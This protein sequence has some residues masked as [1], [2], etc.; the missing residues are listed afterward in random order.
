M[1]HVYEKNG[2]WYGD[3]GEELVHTPKRQR[4]EH[5]TDQNREVVAKRC[6]GI[7]GEM[8]PLDRFHKCSKSFASKRSYCRECEN[9]RRVANTDGRNVYGDEKRDVKP[10]TERVY[11][12][13]ICV[14]KRC[15]RCEEWRSRDEYYPAS[16][17]IDGLATNCKDCAYQLSL[18]SMAKDPERYRAIGQNR[19]AK[20]RALPG[21]LMDAEW[22]ETLDFFDGACAL[23]GVTENLTLEHAIPI[24]IGHGGTVVWNSYP[25]VSPLNSSKQARNLFEWAKKRG[26][27]DKRRFNRLISFLADKCDMTV[28]EYREFYYWCFSNPRLTVEEIEADGDLDSI[29]LWKQARKD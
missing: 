5:L 26:D 4:A 19:R 25:L 7:C 21:D 13:G 27:I 18:V 17:P 15:P 11:V 20:V 24:A 12:E 6:G 29:T 16:G 28:D 10:K 2:N 14:K 8:L 9:K 1:N 23:T 3:N 22:K